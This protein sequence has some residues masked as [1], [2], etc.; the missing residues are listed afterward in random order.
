MHLSLSL[1]VNFAS[2]EKNINEHWAQV[3][4][5]CGELSDVFNLLWNALQHTMDWEMDSL[6]WDKAKILTC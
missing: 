5:L 6:K 1:Y 4:D 2:K 3:N